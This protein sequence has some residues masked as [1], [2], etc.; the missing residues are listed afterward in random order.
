M[1]SSSLITHLRTKTNTPKALLEIQNITEET[2]RSGPDFAKLISIDDG[3]IKKITNVKRLRYPSAYFIYCDLIDRNFNFANN[4]KSD[5]L[6]KIDVKGRA[7][8]KVRYD[9]SP[10]QPIRECSTNPHVNSITISVK[11]QAG[12]LFDF[13]GMPLEFELELN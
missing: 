3:P 1:F 13:K 10:L 4:K 8:E 11:D 6:A 2:I 5:L 9:S 7:Y 12:Q